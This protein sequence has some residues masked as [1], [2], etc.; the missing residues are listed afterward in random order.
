MDKKKGAEDDKVDMGS[1]EEAKCPIES[2][3]S[4]E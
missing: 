4:N 3:K 1:E 2:Y